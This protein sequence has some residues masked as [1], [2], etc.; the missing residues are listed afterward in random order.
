MPS[1]DS[2]APIPLWIIRNAANF[3]KE[4]KPDH[5]SRIDRAVFILIMRRV[6]R[7]GDA[8]LVE[9]DTEVGKSYRV[10]GTT[11]E[12]PD[13][14]YRAPDGLCKHRLAVMLQVHAEHRY[15]RLMAEALFNARREHRSDDRVSV[16]AGLAYAG[17]RS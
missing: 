5:A 7:D 9:S 11:C 4:S 16:A 3:A 6:E 17:S 12:C 14:L 13:H 2:T 15:E 8:W 10:V 1:I